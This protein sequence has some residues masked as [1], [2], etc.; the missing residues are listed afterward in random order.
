MLGCLHGPFAV[1]SNGGSGCRRVD[2]GILEQSLVAAVGPRHVIGLCPLGRLLLL[3]LATAS[4]S[5]FLTREMARA[6]FG[7]DL[8]RAHD[9]EFT[10]IPCS[11]VLSITTGSLQGRPARSF[12][13][14]GVLHVAM[15]C[16]AGPLVGPHKGRPEGLLEGTER[17]HGS[18]FAIPHP[19]PEAT[20]ALLRS[21][22]VLL[23]L[24]NRSA[25]P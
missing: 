25:R 24:R 1:P 11:F 18:D 7:R 10:P 2:V 5:A 20:R 21:R 16:V 4:S 23:D 13:P 17:D 9:S 14:S 12:A 6:T 15:I 3:R 8:G 19:R 22:D